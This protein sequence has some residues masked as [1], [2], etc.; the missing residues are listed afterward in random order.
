MHP[1]QLIA[2]SF[3]DE[4]EALATLRQTCPIQYRD[5]D[6]V[7]TVTSRIVDVYAR[8]RADFIK[9]QGGTVIRADHL[10]SVDG[11]PVQFASSPFSCA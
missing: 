7:Q 10:I 9:L 1:Y 3:H 2:C 6:A 4:L 5:G 11:K 8:D